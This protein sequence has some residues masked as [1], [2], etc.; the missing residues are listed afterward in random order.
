MGTETETGKWLSKDPDSMK[1]AR[2]GRTGQF[3]PE[4]AENK[5]V[6]W[7]RKRDSNPREPFDSNGFQDR[8]IQ[9]LCHS[10]V[11]YRI[12][13]AAFARRGEPETH[14]RLS[15]PTRPV[16]LPVCRRSLRSAAM[17]RAATVKVP[18]NA[19]VIDGAGKTL[20]PGLWDSHMH[21]Q[22][23]VTGPMLLSIGVTSLR[24]PGAPG[25]ALHRSGRADREGRL[26]VPACLLDCADRR[27]WTTRGSGRS[28]GQLGL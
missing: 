27:Q 7:R 25:G 14:S 8:R 10:S 21:V 19:Q 9:P 23:D 17:G 28:C 3:S 18:G 12:R 15:Q 20:V 6:N 26:T 22:D 2:L 24:N 11:F 16:R 4:A 5:R 13:C 1:R